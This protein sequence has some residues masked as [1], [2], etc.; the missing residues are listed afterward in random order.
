MPT[1]DHHADAEASDELLKDS[2]TVYSR[3]YTNDKHHRTHEFW[4]TIALI[5]VTSALS[6]LTGLF[7]GYQHHHSDEICSRRTSHYSTVMSNIPIKYH[8]QRF[9]GSL[10]KENIF[11]QGAGPEVDAAWESL[12]VNYRPISVPAEEATRSGIA[13]DQVQINEAY[14]GGYPANVEGLHHLHCLNLLRQSLY[15]NYDYYRSLGT[16]AFKNEDFIVRYHVSHCLDI[17]RQ[18]LMC[19][20]DVGVLGQVWVHPDK[21]SAFVDFNTEHHC[22]N[23]EQIRDWA[24][25]HQLPEHV[26]KDFLRPPREGDRIYNEI[27]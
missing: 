20:V 25:A 19:T 24:E 9:N 10:L 5:I 23:F 17:L 1:L 16:G 21:P 2:E 4:R 12:G 6:C 18:Q 8:R 14:G 3:T 26:P 15:Y 11:R 22:R 13:P 7:I 27:P